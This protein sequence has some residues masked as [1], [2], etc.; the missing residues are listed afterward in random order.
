MIRNAARRT[1]RET[2]DTGSEKTKRE[3]GGKK[4]TTAL[5]Y[6]FVK[7][8]RRRVAGSRLS[9]NEESNGKKKKNYNYDGEMTKK[10]RGAA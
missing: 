1:D 2:P 6:V 7:I 5:C 10:Q 9:V 4:K 3:D 8:N